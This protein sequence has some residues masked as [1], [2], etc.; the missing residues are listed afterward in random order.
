MEDTT[1]VF[2]Q[3]N[4][5]ARFPTRLK[6]TFDQL[7]LLGFHLTSDA[8]TIPDKN[9]RSK[10]STAGRQGSVMKMFME[11]SVQLP[12]F[13]GAR[14]NVGLLGSFNGRMMSGLGVFDM[15]ATIPRFFL[16]KSSTLMIGLDLETISVPSKVDPSDR[17]GAR[18]ENTS[19]Q[20]SMPP[21]MVESHTPTDWVDK[22]RQL[23]DKYLPGES[24]VVRARYAKLRFLIHATWPVEPLPKQEPPAIPGGYVPPLPTSPVPDWASLVPWVSAPEFDL[25]ETFLLWYAN[26]PF[27]K[28][29]TLTGLPYSMLLKMAQ[30]ARGINLSAH[31]RPNSWV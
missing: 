14:S 5:E 20:V 4:M 1:T 24:D 12:A 25:Y 21:Q 7:P 13:V 28:R 29:P 17:H 9:L 6:S 16:R 30:N 3:F 31:H 26:V 19:A 15:G 11:D 22:Q 27:E 18:P 10:R 8:T 23:L 2:D